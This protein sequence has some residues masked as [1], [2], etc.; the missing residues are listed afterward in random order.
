VGTVSTV[1][2]GEE[3]LVGTGSGFEEQPP[4]TEAIM[5]MIMQKKYND[6]FISILHQIYPGNYQNQ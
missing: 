3:E 6:L 4:N 1:E 2:V 5:I